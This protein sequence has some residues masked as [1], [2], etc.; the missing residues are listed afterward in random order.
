M[1]RR[2]AD[3]KARFNARK[4]ASDL[5][6][7]MEKS[8]PEI[9]VT[10]GTNR[11]M[12]GDR[13]LKLVRR[14]VFEFDQTVMR[15]RR[16]YNHSAKDRVC[17]F[18]LPENLNSNAHVHLGIWFP[19]RPAWDRYP[20]RKALM[21]TLHRDRFIGYGR[22]Y[23]VH[24]SYRFEE[25]QAPLFE[26]LWRKRGQGFHYHAELIDRTIER[27]TGY[28]SKDQNFLDAHPYGLTCYD[29]PQSQP[30]MDQV[31]NATRH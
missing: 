12:P 11:N 8:R 19:R 14:T 20:L 9:M 16:P 7:V 21:R 25:E 31:F 2:E 13:L 3:D 27:L 28:I 15:T 1:T 29:W 5:S 22:N 24:D 30:E 23:D 17:A 4:D 6:R 26:R 18:I 10:L